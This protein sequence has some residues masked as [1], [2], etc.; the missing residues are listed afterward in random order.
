VDDLKV[1]IKK[2]N[3]HTLIGIDAH[4]LNLWKVSESSWCKVDAI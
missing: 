3:E 1:A 4:V 2:K